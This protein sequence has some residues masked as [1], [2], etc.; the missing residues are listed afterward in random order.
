MH[1]GSLQSPTLDW[2]SELTLFLL[3]VLSN[4]TSLSCRFSDDAF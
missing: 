4:E 2:T 3:K 1:I